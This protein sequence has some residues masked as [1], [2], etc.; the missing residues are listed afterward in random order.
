MRLGAARARMWIQNAV[1]GGTPS[2]LPP[3]PLSECGSVPRKED[4][5]RCFP[6]LSAQINLTSI[7]PGSKRLPPQQTQKVAGRICTVLPLPGSTIFRAGAGAVGGPELY[8]D[9]SDGSALGVVPAEGTVPPF[10]VP[11]SVHVPL[12][13]GTN[14][15]HQLT[16]PQGGEGRGDRL[17]NGFP[18]PTGPPPPSSGLTPTQ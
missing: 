2:A 15:S 8:L 16:H 13:Q 17:Q 5:A 18:T 11:W 14:G 10:T 6:K 4:R 3:T 7:T 1:A 12:S 9:S